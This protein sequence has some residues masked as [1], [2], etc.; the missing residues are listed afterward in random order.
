LK[1]FYIQNPKEIKLED[2]INKSSRSIEKAFIEKEIPK[3]EAVV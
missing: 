3:K 2:Y 1:W